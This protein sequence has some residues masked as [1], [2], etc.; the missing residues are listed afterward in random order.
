MFASNPHQ[1]VG[2]FAPLYVGQLR[3]LK[4]GQYG[5]LSSLKMAMTTICIIRR[6][7]DSHYR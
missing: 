1:K 6:K 7:V 3:P 5:A 4:V 2:H